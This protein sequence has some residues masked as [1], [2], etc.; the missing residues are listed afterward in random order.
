MKLRIKVKTNSTIQQVKRISEKDFE[1][2]F[3]AVTE[4]G[5]ANQKLI[6]ILS[7]YFH[8]SKSSVRIINGFTSNLKTIKILEFV[9]M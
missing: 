5:K 7:E 3:K 2:M 8:V 4:K 6:E 9:D 1:V